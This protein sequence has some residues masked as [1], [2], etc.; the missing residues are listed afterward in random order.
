MTHIKN[1]TTYWRN[2]LADGERNEIDPSSVDNKKILFLKPEQINIDSGNIDKSLAN[3][4]F[5]YL[6]KRDDEEENDL[7]ITSI[8]VLISFFT[9]APVAESAIESEEKEMYPFWIKAVLKL[10]GS[11]QPDEES[12][13]YI[14]RVFLEPQLS[15]KYFYTFS[16]VETI[17]KV[18]YDLDYEEN[19]W[20]EYWTYVLGIFRKITEQNITEYK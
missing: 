19:N 12:F 7:N 4:L 18:F 16:D 3:K 9:V 8:P 10:D 5:E 20:A 17:D 1:W 2:T 14:P 13:P 11:L 15:E 6:N